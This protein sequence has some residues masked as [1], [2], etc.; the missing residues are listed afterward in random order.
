MRGVGVGREFVTIYIH[1]FFGGL[2][3]GKVVEP[4]MGWP[5]SF[6]SYTCIYIYHIQYLD[7]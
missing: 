5:V 3:M 6:C 4:S 1:S 7:K 2:G